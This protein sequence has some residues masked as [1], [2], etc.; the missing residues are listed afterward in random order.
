MIIRPLYAYPG[1]SYSL[2]RTADA[3]ETGK[4]RIIAEKNQMISDGRISTTCID[5]AKE[6]QSLWY[7]VP[8]EDTDMESSD[9]IVRQKVQ[10]YDLI[11]GGKG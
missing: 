2:E 1:V 4:V 3:V 9:D 10:A 6:Q 5:V 11:T 8:Y 7:D